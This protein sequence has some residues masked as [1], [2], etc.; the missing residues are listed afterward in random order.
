MIHLVNYLESIE[1]AD[2]KNILFAIKY[3]RTMA[4]WIEHDK[5]ANYEEGIPLDMLVIILQEII[6]VKRKGETF[7]NDYWGNRYTNKPLLSAVKKA[8]QADAVARLTWMK[9]LENRTAVNFGTCDLIIKKHQIEDSI[10]EM[11]SLIYSYYNMEDLVIANECISHFVIRSIISAGSAIAVRDN[12]EKYI[13]E[14]LRKSGREISFIFPQ[15]AINCNDMFR[16]FLIDHSAIGDVVA[17]DVIRQINEMLDDDSILEKGMAVNFESKYTS[18]DAKDF[19]F[20]FV[21]NSRQKVM[22][23]QNF[24]SVSSD[25]RFYRMQELGLSQFARDDIEMFFRAIP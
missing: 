3:A 4:S 15:Q 10:Y 18:E 8:G 6:A 16:E 13:I 24:V 5:N 9:K 11:K 22:V 20:T 23:Y 1:E 12:F 25:D 17:E 19:M 2:E 21:V 14:G 7:K